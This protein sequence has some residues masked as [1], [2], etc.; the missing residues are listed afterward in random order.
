MV[1]IPFNFCEAVPIPIN[2]SNAVIGAVQVA[3]QKIKTWTEIGAILVTIWESKTR[4]V[5][6]PFIPPLCRRDGAVLMVLQ[7]R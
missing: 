3:V 5:L 2:H 4:K 1:P 7:K 6:I